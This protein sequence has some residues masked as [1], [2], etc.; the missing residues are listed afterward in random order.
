ALTLGPSTT[1]T[2]LHALHDERPLQLRDSRDDREHRLAQRRPRVDLLAQTDEL[3]IKVTKEFQRLDQVPHGSSEA[4]ERRDDHDIDAAGLHLA[5]EVVQ[6]RPAFAGTRG[7]VAVLDHVVPSTSGAVRTEV[8]ALVLD[9]L[10]R[11]R[12]AEI[13]T[14]PLHRP[15]PITP[16]LPSS[17]TTQNVSRS[18]STSSGAMSLATSP[19]SRTVLS[20]VVGM[21]PSRT[22]A[23]RN[24]ETRKPGTGSEKE[25]SPRFTLDSLHSPRSGAWVVG[26]ACSQTC[27]HDTGGTGSLSGRLDA[28]T[29]TET[30]GRRSR[31]G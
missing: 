10:L 1:K 22:R 28:Q 13:A 14:H 6:A 8:I 21:L 26:P 17:I 4:V 5:H 16:F 18:R 30:R 3:D 29:R 9:R 24:F 7:R 19:G 20:H 12:D 25:T 23:T 27:R 31:S 2:G 11:G 15:P